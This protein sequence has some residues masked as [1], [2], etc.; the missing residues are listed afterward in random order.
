MIDFHGGPRS[1]FLTWATG[2]PTRIGYAIAGPD[3][4]LHRAAPVDA[5]AGAARAIQSQPVGPAGAAGHR[6]ARDGRPRS[7]CRKRSRGR[8]V[9]DRLASRRRRPATALIVMHVSAG[10]PFR[11]WPQ[12]SFA[13]VAA[14]LAREDRRGGL[15]SAQGHPKRRRRSGRDGAHGGPGR[16]RGGADRALRRVRSVGAARAGRPRG[17]LH[18]RRQRAD[19]HRRHHADADRRAV[20]A[21]AAGA[22]AALA[23][24]RRRAIAVDARTAAVPA[25]PPAHCVPGDFRCL[26][27]I[28]VPERCWRPPPGNWLTR[29]KLSHLTT[30]LSLTAGR[31]PRD[32]VEQAGLCVA[33]RHGRRDAVVDRRRARSCWRVASL[34]WLASA[35]VRG[36]SASRR[37]AFFWPLVAYAALTLRLGGLLARSRASA[38][39]TASSCACSC[40][41]RWS[42]TSRA[43]ARAHTGADAS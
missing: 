15:S 17:A 19:A 9:R 42:T 6:A 25:V 38:S 14:A 30:T 40:S 28:S 35:L 26:T 18:R 5:L 32:R 27:T 34:C 21:D 41:C 23:R 7:R 16:H 22:F 4:G 20:R 33:D 36:A 11:R 43:A 29:D 8:R 1:S 3:L 39:S 10:N 31:R 12:E 37:R 13:E 24:C 2:A